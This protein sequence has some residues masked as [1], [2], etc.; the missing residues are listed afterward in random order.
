MLHAWA[1]QY[2]DVVPTGEAIIG[3]EAVVQHVTSGL[4]R[5]GERVNLDRADKKVSGYLSRS[6]RGAVF[7]IDDDGN[8]WDVFSYEYNNLTPHRLKGFRYQRGEDEAD[9]EDGNP[10]YPNGRCSACGFGLNDN[11]DCTNYDCSRSVENDE[12]AFEEAHA[13]HLD[14][15]SGVNRPDDDR[16][17][18]DRDY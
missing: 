5:F 8:H 15:L 10:A 6:E 17:H 12:D 7:V 9:E 13:A 14:S 18:N 2:D 11:G 4:T 3:R 1:D 16:Q